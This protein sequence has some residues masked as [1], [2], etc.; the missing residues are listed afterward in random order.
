MCLLSYTELFL[1]LVVYTHGRFYCYY[2]NSWELHALPL[3]SL[4]ARDCGM[5]EHIILID[6][7][8]GLLTASTVWECGYAESS[9]GH[10]IILEPNSHFDLGSWSWSGWWQCYPRTDI[11]AILDNIKWHS[12][13]AIYWSSIFACLVIWVDEFVLSTGPLPSLRCLDE[14]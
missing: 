6:L 5:C 3:S 13:C 9:V 1:W 10:M 7:V 8:P 11:A 14:E 12:A 2:S 4:S